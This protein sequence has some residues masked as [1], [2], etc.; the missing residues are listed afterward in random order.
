[1][2]RSVGRVL[3]LRFEE[4]QGGDSPEALCC[5]FKQDTLFAA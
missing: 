2:V 3:D 4:L 1:M 5:V